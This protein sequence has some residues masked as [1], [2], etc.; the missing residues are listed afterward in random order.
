MVP[1]D[2]SPP[3]RLGTGAGPGHPTT[4]YPSPG[5]GTASSREHEDRDLIPSS[6]RGAARRAIRPASQEDVRRRLA[7]ASD[8]RRTHRDRYSGAYPGVRLPRERRLLVDYRASRR[9]A[10]PVRLPSEEAW[11]GGLKDWAEYCRK[12]GWEVLLSP[13]GQR[14]A[15]VR[16]GDRD[17]SRSR[18]RTSENAPTSLRA[19]V[20][21]VDNDARFTSRVTVESIAESSERGKSRRRIPR[22]YSLAASRR[23]ANLRDLTTSGR[24]AES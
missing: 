15:P 6:Y 1:R 23:R 13:R 9:N 4:R 2:V 21:S 10:E 5:A 3:G 20:I 7:R 16:R 8:A 17:R 22:R 18:S 14:V 11:D 12:K 24:Q 19:R